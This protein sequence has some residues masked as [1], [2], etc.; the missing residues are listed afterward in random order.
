MDFI[1]QMSSS[2]DKI[3][4]RLLNIYKMRKAEQ[5]GQKVATKDYMMAD[6]DPM[7]SAS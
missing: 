4:E 5:T 3:D 2:K 7:E 1:N 6:P